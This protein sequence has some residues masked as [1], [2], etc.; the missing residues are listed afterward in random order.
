M[1]EYISSMQEVRAIKKNGYRVASTFSGCGG[2]CLGYR[3]AGFEVVW[4]NEFIEVARKTYSLNHPSYVCPDDIRKIDGDDL[5]AKI[6][7]I[8]L[9]DGSP[10][11]SAFSTS[12]SREKGWSKVKSYSDKSQ[13]VDDLFFEYARILRSLQPK[14]F[15][16]ENVSGL[17]KGKAR[18]YYNLILDALSSSGYQVKSFLLN[19]SSFGVPQNRSRLFFIGARNDLGKTPS[20]PKQ[21]KYMSVM[22]DYD[23]LK[24]IVSFM[25]GGKKFNWQSARNRPY[26]TVTAS[27]YGLSPTAYL[28]ANGYVKD[29]Q[30]DI[31]KL[32]ITEGKVIC[33]FPKDF[34]L[35]GTLDKQWE[36]LG[37][38][39]PPILMANIADHVRKTLLE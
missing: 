12:G 36:R 32:T 14:V 33:S 19:A 28:S 15:V 17:I 8:D 9:L 20:L 27:L 21:N 22:R 18:G 34:Q 4:A 7:E 2:S 3:I 29:K 24:D 35:T 30:G 26:L 23:D 11:C 38:S 6:G 5:K 31:R 39:V 37:R 16:A 10:P 25:A 1:I 13:R